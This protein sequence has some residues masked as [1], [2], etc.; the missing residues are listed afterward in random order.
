M[1]RAWERGVR[2]S[3]A[4]AVVLLVG[5]QVVA[6]AEASER[7]RGGLATGMAD[8][9]VSGNGSSVI[10]HNPAALGVVAGYH[11]EVG[12]QRGFDGDVNSFGLAVVDSSTNPLLAGGVAYQFHRGRGLEGFDDVREHEIRSSLSAPL[13][14][15]RILFGFGARYLFHNRTLEGPSPSGLRLGG[16]GIGDEVVPPIA[17]PQESSSSLRRRTRG[18]AWDIG[19]FG[20]V[21]D[22]FG[23][24]AAFQNLGGPDNWE[25][26]RVLRLGAGIYTGGFRLL[27]EWGMTFPEEAD[28]QS[29][30][31]VAAE[32]EFQPFSLRT[33]IRRDELS[34]A[35]FWAIG[36]GWYDQGGGIEV[37]Y[38]GDVLSPDHQRLMVFLRLR[39]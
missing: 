11:A 37:A 4:V 31:G 33:G 27:G 9:Y 17:P 29:H 8:V 23:I 5:L 34:S 19:L 3:G 13:V 2:R 35:T 38:Q 1:I 21:T 6:F 36:G 18:L 24:S 20:I 26:E 14:P 30:F 25:G 22:F 7:Y 10:F 28:N 16:I 15:G 39:M 32:M 12:Y